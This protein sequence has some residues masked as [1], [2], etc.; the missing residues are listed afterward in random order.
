MAR[1]VQP[2]RIERDLPQLV[3]GDY[4][5]LSWIADDLVG[6]K[7][8]PSYIDSGYDLKVGQARAGISVSRPGQS[9]EQLR[10]Y[11]KF[12]SSKA[13][14]QTSVDPEDAKKRLLTTLSE[15]EMAG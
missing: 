5:H 1:I 11:V 7:D 9:E 8:S 15:V 3:C 12:I 10:C 14:R 4:E 2:R 6:G 13:S